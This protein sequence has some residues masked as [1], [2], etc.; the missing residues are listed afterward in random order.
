MS[1]EVSG[2]EDEFLAGVG[3][4]GTVAGPWQTLIN[5]DIG[6]P[7]AGPGEDFVAY[8]AFLKLFG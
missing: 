6:F 8:V 1:D 3:L 5:F 2:F 7:V 4:N